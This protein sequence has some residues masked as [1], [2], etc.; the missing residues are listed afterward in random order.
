M[1]VFA[2]M[3]IIIWRRAIYSNADDVSVS[4]RIN[5]LTEFAKSADFSMR[6]KKNKKK[7]SKISE[8]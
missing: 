7:E 6:I 1:P 3:I 5:Y 2:P 8:L 4:S